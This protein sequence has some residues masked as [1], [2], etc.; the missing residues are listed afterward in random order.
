MKRSILMLL[1]AGATLLG[2]L[3]TTTP[4][5]AQK[6]KIA[7]LVLATSERDTDL[8]DNVTEMIIAAV[9]RRGGVEIAGK[10][11]FR[12]RLRLETEWKAQECLDDMSCLGRTAVLLGV[13]R[14]VAGSVGT[15]GKQFLFTLGLNNVESGKVENRM[16]RLIEG[17]LEDLIRAINDSTGELFRPKVAPG[18]IQ[19]SSGLVS[20]RVAIDN[21]YLGVT[22]LISG[23]LLP[24]PH[25]VHVEADNRFSW[26]TTVDVGPGQ[27]LS[28]NLSETNL[29]QRRL[30]PTRSVIGTSIL[31]AASFAAGGFLG[32]LSQV[33]P[34]GETREAAQND[35]RQKERLARG[36]NGA[37]I[38]GGALTA[39]GAAIFA[40]YSDDIL[41]RSE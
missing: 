27:E 26:M 14:I 32:V 19:V 41:G 8:A 30:W 24:G 39:I 9:A 16:F 17:G 22:P 37:F 33:N 5:L 6:E 4:A 29:P 23:T 35:F 1:A 2:G 13:R 3:F 25:R 18:R 10:E 15:R 28:I 38:A 20:A 36:A 12:T 31:A 7:V 40:L 11:E 34:A 21:A